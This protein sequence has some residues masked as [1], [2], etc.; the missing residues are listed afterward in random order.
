MLSQTEHLARS[1]CQHL[2]K[3]RALGPTVWNEPMDSF[4]TIVL[5][6]RT[7]RSR[8]VLSGYKSHTIM[9]AQPGC[10]TT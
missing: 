8:E 3:A 5:P 1:P 9:V 10:V 6:K 2:E 7:M 4:N